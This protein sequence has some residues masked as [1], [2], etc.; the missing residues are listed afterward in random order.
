M[1]GPRH[2]GPV[3]ARLSW[4]VNGAIAQAAE[5]CSGGEVSGGQGF[6]LVERGSSGADDCP[7]RDGHPCLAQPGYRHEDDVGADAVLDQPLGQHLSGLVEE[8]ARRGARPPEVVPLVVAAFGLTA[9]ER[10]VVALV[11]QGLDTKEIGG[12][13]HLSVWT[14]QDHLKA[15]FDKASVRSRRELIARVYFDQYVPRLGTSV[16]PGGWFAA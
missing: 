10:D 11:L 7:H 16:G 1:D 15:I 4:Q 6:L 3:V 2:P 13:L 8:R 12:Q 5:L 14:V 9:R